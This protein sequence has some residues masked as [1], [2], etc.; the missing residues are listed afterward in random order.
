MS[1]L[2]KRRSLRREA[3]LTAP[4]LALVAMSI[5]GMSLAHADTTAILWAGLILLMFGGTIRFCAVVPTE[6]ITKET[7][8]DDLVSKSLDLVSRQVRPHI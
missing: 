7:A 4:L 6:H 2:A 1:T 5:L 3:R 8:T